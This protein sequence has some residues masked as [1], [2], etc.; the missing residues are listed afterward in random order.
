MLFM[1]VEHFKVGLEPVAER[2]R[3][4]GRMLPEGVTYQASW[5]ESTGARCFQLMDAIHAEALQAWIKAW[6][7][8]VDFEVFPVQTSSDFWSTHRPKSL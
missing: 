1:V 3:N 5:M 2:F 8:V 4:S 7:D 6:D